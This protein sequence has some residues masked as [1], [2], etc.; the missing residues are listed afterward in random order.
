MPTLK[1]MA[2]GRETQQLA[3]DPGPSL[4]ALLDAAWLPVR[5]GCRGTGACGLCRVRIDPVDAGA[6]Q[7]SETLH[8]EPSQLAAGERL[9]CQ[10]FPDQDLAVEILAPARAFEPRPRR[11]GLAD[12]PPSPA[13]CPAVASHPEGLGVAVDLGTTLLSLSLCDLHSGAR[14]ADCEGLNP[15]ARSGA[16]VVSRLQA[17]MESPEQRHALAQMVV[18]AIGAALWDMTVRAQVSLTQVRRLTIVGN[19]AMLALLAASDVSRQLQPRYWDQAC[20]ALSYDAETWALGWGIAPQAQIEVLTPLGGF[21]GSDLLAAALAVDLGA[22]ATPTLLIDFGTNSEIGLWDGEHFW[23]TAAAGGPAFEGSGISCGWPAERGAITHVRTHGEALELEVIG[24][25]Q[26]RGLCGSGLVDLLGTLVRSGQLTAMGR[27]ASD[28][29]RDGFPLSTPLGSA[30]H[31]SLLLTKS[32]VDSFQRAKAAVGAGVQALL[33]QAGLSAAAIGQVWLAGAFGAAL[34]LDNAR[35]LGLLPE[36][37][38]VRFGFAG[39]AAL[40]GC[41]QALLASTAKAQVELLRTRTRQVN[42]AQYEGFEACFMQHLYL[43]PQT[44][45]GDER[46]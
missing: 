44:Y 38:D 11:A 24:G 19:S 7:L 10:V 29:P 17:A 43:Q 40:A 15:Q 42:L 33:D 21:V 23:V 39:D 16:D 32:D 25:G 9:A 18:E 2:H 37:P 31:A 5:C 36:L 35:A 1:L 27:F 46:R 26:A 4:M 41:E 3:F 8:L 22:H 30:A 14:L 6:A 28:I 13:A 45:T 12:T 20:S 34:D